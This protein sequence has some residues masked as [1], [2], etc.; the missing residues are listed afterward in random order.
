M[1]KLHHAFLALQEGKGLLSPCNWLLCKWLEVVYFH[2]NAP[3]LSAIRDMYTL[4]QEST[5]RPTWCRELVAGWPEYNGVV[6]ASSHGAGGIIIGELSPCQPT[7]F[8]QQ[9]PPDITS[10]II[11]NLGHKQRRKINK[12]GPQNVRTPPVPHFGK[13]LWHYSVIIA[14]PSAGF[15][16][17]RVNQASWPNN[18][19]ESSCYVSMN[20]GAVI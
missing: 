3:L 12:L 17:W 16:A 9:W 4:I 11:G 2:H 6:D 7:V 5:S 20:N 13:S 18:S 14:Q 1:A 15:S 8:Q 10:D 19:Y